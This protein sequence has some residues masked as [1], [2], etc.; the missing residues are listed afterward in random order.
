MRSSA[1]FRTVFS[2]SQNANVLDVEN[3]ILTQND[4]SRSFKVIRFG[5]NEEPPWSCIVQYNNCGHECEGSE[6][7]ASERS[8]N[9]HLRRPHTPVG[10]GDSRV[11]ASRISKQ[12]GPGSIPGGGKEV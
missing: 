4:R 6:D 1:N 8:E 2:E 3:Q 12:E 10:G 11:V 5:A 9:R 7:I